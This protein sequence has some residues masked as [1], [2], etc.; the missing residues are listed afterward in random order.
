MSVVYLTI[1]PNGSEFSQGVWISFFLFYWLA[2]SLRSFTGFDHIPPMHVHIILLRNTKSRSSR[3]IVAG[4]T[5]QWFWWKYFAHNFILHSECSKK[6]PRL[7]ILHINTGAYPLWAPGA[8]Y[9]CFGEGKEGWQNML[10]FRLRQKHMTHLCL[11]QCMP[12]TRDETEELLK[13]GCRR[14]SIREKHMALTQRAAENKSDCDKV[15]QKRQNLFSLPKHKHT[16]PGTQSG[17]APLFQCSIGSLRIF[18]ELSEWSMKLWAKYFHQNRWFVTP[19]TISRLLLL[20][21]FL[22]KII[23]TCISS[24][25]SNPVKLRRDST[26]Q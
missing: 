18:F 16:A 1:V 19:A 24:M 25:W 9:L 17:Y 22:S 23:C 6:I 3:E 13:E 14:L 8:V 4:V 10:R 2:L 20:F 7:P 21:V 11:C 12:R 5:N 15:W 26:R